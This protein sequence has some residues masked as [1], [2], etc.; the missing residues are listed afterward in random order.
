MSTTVT[1]KGQ[2]TIPSSVR[3][4]LGLEPGSKVQFRLSENGQVILEPETVQSRPRRFANLRGVA[5]IRMSTEEIMAL[6]RGDE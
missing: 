2:V 3:K 4:A 6:T 5:T 1:T